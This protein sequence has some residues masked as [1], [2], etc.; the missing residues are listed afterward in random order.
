MKQ[1]IKKNGVRLSEVPVPTVDKN[2]IIVKVKFSCV[3]QGTELNIIGKKSGDNLITKGLKS[4]QEHGVKKTVERIVDYRN[5]SPTAQKLGYSISGVVEQVGH[6]VKHIREGDR[7]ACA[8]SGLANHA[9]YVHVP[10]NLV[11]KIPQ[12]VA[13]KEASTV[14]MGAIALQGIR[15]GDF[16]LGEFVVVYGLGLIGQL[17][18][19]ILVASGCRVIGIDISEERSDMAKRA[20]MEKVLT[21]TNDGNIEEEVLKKTGGYGTDGVIF[22]AATDDPDVLTSA[23]K[24]TRKKGKVIL[25][26]VAGNEVKREDL[27][28]KELDY[29]ISTSYGPGRYDEQYE[30]KGK[31]YPYAYVR[32]TENRNMQEYIRLLAQGKI[33][34]DIYSST[35]FN[36]ENAVE[37]YKKLQSDHVNPLIAYVDYDRPDS[38]SSA[39]STIKIY[40]P[41]KQRDLINIG[42]V[43]AGNFAKSTHLPNL[44]ELGNKFNIY[45]ICTNDPLNTTETAEKFSAQMATTDYNELLKDQNIDA[46]IIC[47]RHD[48]HAGMAKKALLKNKAVFLEKPMATSIE[49][50]EE[51]YAIVN[52]SEVPFMVGFNRRYSPF[53]RMIRDKI[54]DRLHPLIINYRM[55][56]GYLPESHWVHSEEG[57]GRLIGEVCHMVDLCNYFT[58]SEIESVFSEHIS[59][60]NEYYLEEDNAVITINYIDGSLSN[61]IYSSMGHQSYPKEHFELFCDGNV[62]EMEDFRVLRSYG[63]YNLNVEQKKRDK[64]YIRELEHFFDLI[65]GKASVDLQSYYQT[66]LT[67]L[68]I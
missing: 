13:F 62:V 1:I 57:G 49:E 60:G 63:S 6:S 18:A 30:K 21:P 46:V 58:D 4:L 37:G 28:E 41:K 14:A 38:V 44:L 19:Q 7:V 15:R 9:E 51:L 55:N 3:S 26:G 65:C 59:P 20:G 39:K 45:A 25:V 66:T 8:G 34:L 40:Q 32:W 22:T 31:D 54:K 24:M 50:L 33:K 67:T 48:K 27:Y 56:A 52:K 47:T 68:L 35:V 17:A 11:V 53:A 29:L 2:G 61:L 23:F 16:S 64:G 10:R 12:A 36:I 5:D 42:L 43:G